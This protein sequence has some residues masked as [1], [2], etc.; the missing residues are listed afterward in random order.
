ME[1]IVQSQ[2][3]EETIQVE[4]ATFGRVLNEPLIHQV[5]IAYQAHA[6]AGT[7]AQKNRS[8]VSGGGKKPWRQ[9]GTGKARAGTI[10]SPIWRGGGRAFP[11]MPRNFSQKVNKK[12]YRG[13]MASIVSELIRQSRIKI[14]SLLNVEEPKTKALVAKLQELGYKYS[15]KSRLL[16]IVDEMN[17]N[18]YLAA[19]NLVGVNVCAV[20]SANPVNLLNCDQIII[21][22]EA[23]KRLEALLK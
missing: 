7:K 23:I 17:A 13:A 3:G 4:D 1:L 15:G 16:I 6:R 9:K 5:V 20:Q 14:S 22:P 2:S 21:A 11:G 12:M 18:L 19:R 10:R 8:Q